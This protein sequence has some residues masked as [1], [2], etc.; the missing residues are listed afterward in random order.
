MVQTSRLALAALVLCSAFV[1]PAFAGRQLKQSTGTI[2]FPGCT[3][4]GDS[5]IAVNKDFS[6]VYSLLQA[7]GLN[8]TLSSLSSP[9]T[10]FIPT[11]EALAEYLEAANLTLAEA[12]SSPA[13][14]AVLSYHVVSGA[15]MS[16]SS[17]ADGQ[18]LDTMLAGTNLTIMTDEIN[19]TE[20]ITVDSFGAEV[21]IV[22]PAAFACNLVIYGIDGVLVPEME[23][24]PFSDEF[25]QYLEVTLMPGAAEVPLS[26]VMAAVQAG[27]VNV[28]AEAADQAVNMGYLQQLT[29]LVSAS[30]GVTGGIQSL[31]AVGNVMIEMTSCGTVSP[32]IQQSMP[33]VT[34]MGLSTSTLSSLATQY[35]ALAAC[36]M[37]Q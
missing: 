30:Q 11:N 16:E 18:V 3:F 31:A 24:V 23:L 37:V 35:P 17:F 15:I 28:V 14:R 6:D 8:S 4:L 12:A 32:L 19:G 34:S 33:I 36:V 2:M 13:L 1:A 22:T 9:A 20:Y 7:S 5:E 29:A 25:L 10:V 21:T 27:D 26:L